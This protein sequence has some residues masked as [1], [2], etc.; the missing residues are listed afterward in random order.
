M[1]SM[2]NAK[3]DPYVMVSY[4]FLCSTKKGNRLYKK[5][6]KFKTIYPNYQPLTPQQADEL[7]AQRVTEP[8]V[9]KNAHVVC[10]D[11]AIAQQ[12]GVQTDR[13]T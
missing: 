11:N 10:V 1:Q 7:I 8:P 9:P 13:L 6:T 3:Q 4:K 2:L 12:T 5:F